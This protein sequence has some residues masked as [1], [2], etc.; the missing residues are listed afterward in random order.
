MRFNPVTGTKEQRAQLR[1]RFDT[2]M[3]PDSALA[4][5]REHVC[6]HAKRATCS[7]ARVPGNRFVIRVDTE[8]DDGT[9][10]HLRAQGLRG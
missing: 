7:P 2:L 6:P 3:Q 8:A 10:A 9:R 4:V 1:R 5:V